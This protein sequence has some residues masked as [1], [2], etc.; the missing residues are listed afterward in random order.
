MSGIEEIKIWLNFTYDVAKNAVIGEF[1]SRN[2]PIVDTAKKYG[3]GGH[4]FAC[5][6]TIADWDMVD[7]V[8]EDFVILLKESENAS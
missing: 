7:K 6:A 3:G 4:L 2:V 1:R 5:G 8:I